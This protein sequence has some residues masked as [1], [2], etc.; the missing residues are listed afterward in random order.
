MPFT[1]CRI[2]FD[3]ALEEILQLVALRVL[4]LHSVTIRIHET[5]HPDCHVF[6][7][8]SFVKSLLSTCPLI[9]KRLQLGV[10]TV[11]R[12]VI[13]GLLS[14]DILEKQP[15]RDY[16]GLDVRD[17]CWT[18]AFDAD[19]VDVDLGVESQNG[20]LIQAG[21]SERLEYDLNLKRGGVTYLDL[22]GDLPDHGRSRRRQVDGLGGEVVDLDLRSRDVC[23]VG[24]L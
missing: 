18:G 7:V 8:A 14:I 6:I 21:L 10:F 16:F 19:G 3:V 2:S 20:N 4:R 9:P 12:I 11:A 1:L 17:G 22:G 23:H 15:S 24:C 5:Q 13:I